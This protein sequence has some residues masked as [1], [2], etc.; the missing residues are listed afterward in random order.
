MGLDVVELMMRIEEE[1]AIAIEDEEASQ[2]ETVGQLHLC[3]LGKLGLTASNRCISSATFYQ[4]RRALVDL[5]GSSRRFI[6]P[7]TPTELLLSLPNRRQQWRDLGDV[8]GAK[9]PTLER[10]KWVTT[11]LRN[12]GILLAVSTFIVGLDSFS[13]AVSSA[14]SSALVLWI[15]SRWSESYAIQLPASCAT[16]GG[17]TKTMLKLNYGMN[18]EKENTW[19]ER[20]VWDKLRD[21]LVDE[22]AVDPTQI[23]PE[24]R[25]VGD[26]RLD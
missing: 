2:L 16:V 22:L 26:L 1:F 10:P 4:L 24:A 20:A 7:S 15:A 23:K 18:I 21:I 6:R 14:L 9:L 3:V 5:S 8:T 25:F 19:V 11:A 13:L 17:M 12:G